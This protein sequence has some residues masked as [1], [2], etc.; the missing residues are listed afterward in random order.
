MDADGSNVVRLTDD[1][2][3]SH[4]SAWLGWSRSGWRRM[5]Q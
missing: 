1:D 5:S 3:M 2:A 4:L